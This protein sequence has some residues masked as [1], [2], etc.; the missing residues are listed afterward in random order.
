MSYLKT[1]HVTAKNLPAWSPQ[2]TPIYDMAKTYLENAE[3]GPFFNGA[4]PALSRP[5]KDRWINFLGLQAAS[6]IGI[7]AGPLLN[8]KW[9]EFAADF[10]YDILCYKTI[11]SFAH[12]GHSLPN[13]IFVDSPQQLNPNAL[14]PHLTQKD[15]NPPS[16]N[17]LAITNS[18]GMPSRSREYLQK[19][20]P[21]A[22]S[23][24]R[25]GQILIVSIVGTPPCTQ[26]PDP[27]IDN[28][29]DTACLAKEC[30]AKVIEANFSCPNVSTGEGC[31]Y[32]NP[33]A[34]YSISKKIKQVLKDIPLILK[35][36]VFPNLDLMEK[37]LIS[38]AKAGVQA[39]GGINTLSMKV[40]NAQGHPALGPQRLTSGICGSP[41]RQAAVEF[42]K[43]AQIINK[44]HRLGLT[45]I[46]T[47]GITLPEHFDE[48]FA[49]EADVAMT[50]TG[51]MWDP[52]L[53]LRYQYGNP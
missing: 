27:F 25:E 10:G 52:Y 38:A 32:Y 39:I 6:P 18:F 11:R 1:N 14:P 4:L 31:L 5:P 15:A 33:E 34:V 43:Q 35:M 16:L 13:V 29:V 17:D 28:F 9:V 36:G 41:I 42:I 12:P 7:P 2:L 19:D 51:M 53:S 49:A 8:A 24:L 46:G 20:I 26:Q 50:A 47:G 23:K 21:L 44:K 37:A 3:H 30:G 45:L 40:L 22:Q 48:F